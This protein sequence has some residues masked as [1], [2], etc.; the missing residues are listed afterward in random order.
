[1]GGTPLEI[2]CS[3][4]GKES[5]LVRGPKY[6]GFKRVGEELACSACGHVY[7]S[8]AEVPFK[9]AMTVPKVFDET[10]RSAT[11]DVFAGD[12][13]GRLCR[14][15]RQYVVNPFRQWCGLHKKEV[16]A[17]DTCSSFEPRP[18]PPI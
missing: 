16:Q 12:E 18:A 3:A 17:T 13:R 10:D 9:A 15:C 5:L 11:P 8:E 7:L 6:E 2:I 14:Y 4:C 1:M